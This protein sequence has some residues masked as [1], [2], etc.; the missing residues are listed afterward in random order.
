MGNTSSTLSVQELSRL[1][2]S[3]VMNSPEAVRN[4]SLKP[5]WL[6][7]QPGL[8]LDILD[9]T[10]QPLIRAAVAHDDR[11]RPLMSSSHLPE[12]VFWQR[13]FAAALQLS[14][15]P[16]AATPAAP[17]R[18]APPGQTAGTPD[19]DDTDTDAILLSKV[20]ECFLYKI[21]PRP[22]A[23][24]W[25]ASEWPGGLDNPWRTGYL[26]V[27]G[28]GRQLAV[29]VWERP[30]P[31][32]SQKQQPAKQPAASDVAGAPALLGHHL[33]LT[34][35]FDILDSR[36]SSFFIEPVLDSSRYFVLRLE[37]KDGRTA[38][39]GLG[40]RE[41][42][43]AFELKQCLHHFEE[44]HRRQARGLQLS[45]D[46]VDAGSGGGGGGAEVAEPADDAVADRLGIEHLSLTSAET[47]GKIRVA[48]PTRR[49]LAS[50]SLMPPTAPS[51]GSPV[52]R[53]ASASGML[54]LPPPRSGADRLPGQGRPEVSNAGNT[55]EHQ[56][57][58]R[59][60]R[61]VPDV[62][63]HDQR[64]AEEDDFGDFEAAAADR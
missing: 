20:D 7:T 34:C 46:R 64:E 53:G 28:H 40:F 38:F 44:Q 36:G 15:V 56:V 19:A 17:A 8:D 50:P 35:R 27:T 29:A 52:L 23:A 55:A 51:A 6:A 41:R 31:G 4:L 3:C 10:I 30:T 59:L 61:A 60:V 11:L 16:D 9:V 12:T 43:H 57:A 42:N 32:S 24:G 2:F 48:L 47:D 13:Y 22:S 5:D 62:A 14:R 18:V 33:V 1:Y 54:L 25:K 49:A 45:D 37:S 63:E 26:R 21:P 39:V 58:P